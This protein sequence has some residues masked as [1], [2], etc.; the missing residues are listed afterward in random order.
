MATFDPRDP[1]DANE[2]PDQDGNWDCSGATCE[3]TA[4]T[5]FME[6]YA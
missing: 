1:L 6:F 4:Y 3:Y 2:D 5:N